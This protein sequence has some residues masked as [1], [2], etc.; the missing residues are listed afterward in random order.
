MFKQLHFLAAPAALSLLMTVSP[1]AA[2]A[3]DSDDSVTFSMVVSAGAKTCLP[4]ASATVKITPAGPIELMDVTVQGLPP[5]TE[6]DFFVIQ[7]PKSPF[8]VSWYQGDIE[9]DKNGRGH[10]QFVG[11]FSIET[12]AVAPGSAAAPVVFNGPFPDASLNPPFNPI[13]MYHLGLWFGSPQDAQAA[14][15]PATVTPFNGEHNAGIQV[16][17][18]SNFADDHG[19]L[20]QVNPSAQKPKN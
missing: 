7:V 6:F 3:N 13:Q 17:N 14:G 20:R 11:R 16:L 15:C 10:Q 4:N 19:P 1:L 8:G 5:K 12:F 18:T 2:S 9:T